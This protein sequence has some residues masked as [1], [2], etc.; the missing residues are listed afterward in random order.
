MKK[1]EV[2]GCEIEMV[3][4]RGA[5]FYKGAQNMDSLQHNF[6]LDSYEEG[7]V[8]VVTVEDFY[9]SPVT[10]T[11]KLW[12]AVGALPQG[13]QYKGDNRPVTWVTYTDVRLWLEKLNVALRKDG[14]LGENYVIDLPDEAQWEFAARGGKENKGYRIAGSLYIDDVAWYDDK[15][16]C[17]GPQEVA[18]KKPNEL[19]LYDMCGNVDEWTKT[20]DA[21][22]R[23]IVRGGNYHSPYNDCRITARKHYTPMTTSNMIG[24][25]LVMR[26]RN[27]KSGTD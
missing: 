25:R 9:I 20:R 24:F 4:V 11:Q 10:V 3:E 8:E 22:G 1:F 26:K 17:E 21:N 23:I 15:T 6:D 13:M 7:P 19:G 18:R 2:N 12:S 16:E 5:S 27:Q 14:Q